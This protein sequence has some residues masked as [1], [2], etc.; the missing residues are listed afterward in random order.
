MSDKDPCVKSF[1]HESMAVSHEISESD[2]PYI[3]KKYK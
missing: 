3:Y 1:L 2:E